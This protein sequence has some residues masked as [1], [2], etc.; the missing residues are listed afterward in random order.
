MG[1]LK[2][3]AIAGNPVL[4]SKSPD[5]FRA[6]FEK[7]AM[8]KRCYLR[9]AA[10]RPE[11]VLQVMREIPVSGFNITSPFKEEIIPLL[12]EVDETVRKIGAANAVIA[13]GGKLRGFNTDFVGVEGAFRENGI[14]LAGKKAVVLGAGGAARAAVAA[15]VPAGADVV[16]VNRTLQKARLIAETF[17]CGASPMEDLEERTGEADIF[18]SCLPVDKHI[19][20]TRSLR[21]G[22]VI[23]DAN[24]GETVE[25]A[26]EGARH[27]C[28]IIDGREWL[29]YQGVAAFSL[30][31]GLK[32]PPVEVMRESIYGRTT[33]KRNIAIIG[34]MGTGKSVVGRL[35][36][37]RLRMPFVDVDDEIE[38]KNDLTVEDIF[39]RDGEEEF[40]KMEADEIE[41][42]AGLPGRVIS[43][44][45]G[46]V[47]N[48]SAMRR[49]KE[50]SV[51]VWLWA[52]V[53]TI[54][55]RTEHNGARPLLNVEDRKSEIERMLLFRKPFYAGNSD[56]FIRTDDRS[57]EEIAERICHESGKFLTG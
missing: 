18:V 53:D 14:T 42:I 37:E 6:A 54:L 7:L 51:M 57:P 9:F 8:D 31:T 50:R 10:S 49:L 11:E 19:V 36:A 26:K 27:G 52:G 35:V 45:G 55:K 16:V 48:E 38:K 5:M 44:G 43:C 41:Y 25:L 47:L 39:R 56:L 1:D 30:F 12:D 29:L 32:T 13:E 40:R 20:P 21:P 3:F 4:H 22:L 24:Y 46:A 34:F 23:F 15:L 28:T 33:R 2:L 17:S